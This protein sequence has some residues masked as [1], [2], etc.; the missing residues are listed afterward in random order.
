[1]SSVGTRGVGALTGFRGFVF[2]FSTGGRN[3]C[4]Q[5]RMLGRWAH[6][7]CRGDVVF[8]RGMTQINWTMWG[9]ADRVEVRFRSSKR[10]WN[11]T[12]MT[13]ARV[14]PPLLL[15]D[16]GEA[17]EL[18]IE[19]CLFVCFFP[20]TCRWRRLVPRVATGLSGHRRGRQLSF[21]E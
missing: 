4:E 13:R 8:F 9:Q 16:G 2:P 5:G 1:M 3:V 18:M 17:V 20:T 6:I 15:W 14:D 7:V 19:F 10:P 21:A 11:R 12:V